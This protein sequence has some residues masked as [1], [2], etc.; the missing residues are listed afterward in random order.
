LI[1][2]GATPLWVACEIWGPSRALIVF[3]LKQGARFNLRDGQVFPK[4]SSNGKLGLSLAR[5]EMK[6]QAE[7]YHKKQEKFRRLFKEKAT[8]L[9][10]LPEGIPQLVVKFLE[11]DFQKKYALKELTRAA[12]CV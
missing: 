4:L 6:Q 11:P 10:L 8:Y 7:A 5:I 12:E 2:A 9:G 3:L 1:P